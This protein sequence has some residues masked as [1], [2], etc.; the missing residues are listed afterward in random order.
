[1]PS[2]SCCC[3]FISS[4]FYQKSEKTLG[5]W[6]GQP[7]NFTAQIAICQKKKKKSEQN[8]TERNRTE[9]KKSSVSR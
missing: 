2:K 9:N 1:M 5:N 8:G 3:F 6:R 7:Q 4:K